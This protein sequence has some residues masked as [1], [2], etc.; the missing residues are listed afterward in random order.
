MEKFEKLFFNM[1]SKE[2]GFFMKDYHS[3]YSDKDKWIGVLDLG[4]SIYTVIVTTDV[5]ESV[6]YNE[7]KEFLGRAFNKPYS[8][9][10]VIVINGDYILIDKESYKNK[11]IFSL[12]DQKISYCH[13]SCKP[14]GQ[15]ID[16]MV[17]VDI[18]PK[19]KINKY[20]ATYILI[21]LNILIY[22]VSVIKAR[23]LF[24]IDI[25]TLANMGA[26]VNV[27]INDGQVWRLI[28]AAFLHGGL[29]HIGFNMMAL[30]VI[31]P[32][33]EKIY[34]W[35]K[36]LI[37]YF[38]SALGGSLLSYM[39]SPQSISVGAS[40]AVFGLLGSMLVFGVINK[41][42]IGKSFMMNIIEVIVLNIII[43]LSVPNIDNFGHFGGLILGGLT[44]LIFYWLGKK[45][46]H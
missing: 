16:K 23:N 8:L 21:S 39:L 12:G 40:G 28:T 33:V 37:I 3:K 36:Y 24:E 1:L 13:E 11:L 27:L 35:K 42:S 20:K 10:S 26:K 34:G 31:G 29:V 45:E 5:E 14:L 43:G 17:K 32:Q 41:K 22:L 7:A 4:E 15:I 38:L 2:A 6:N 30:N 9:N 19:E 25:Y 46:A 18:T 44:A